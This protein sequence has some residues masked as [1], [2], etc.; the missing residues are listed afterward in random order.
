MVEES[1]KTPW[2]CSVLYTPHHVPYGMGGFHGF[3]IGSIHDAFLILSLDI[4]FLFFFYSIWWSNCVS[5]V[6]WAWLVELIMCMLGTNHTDAMFQE[7]T[8]DLWFIFFYLSFYPIWIPWLKVESMQDSALGVLHT[9]AIISR[10][11]VAVFQLVT[12]CK[13]KKFMTSYI[14]TSPKPSGFEGKQLRD[15]I[16]ACT[17]LLLLLSFIFILFLL[18]TESSPDQSFS[19]WLDGRVECRHMG[20]LHW[21]RQWHTSI[22]LSLC[23]K[24]PESF[25]VWRICWEKVE[26]KLN[27]S[28]F[29]FISIFSILLLFWLGSMWVHAFVP[30]LFVK[31]IR[32]SFTSHIY[33]FP[34]LIFPK[35]SKNF[36]F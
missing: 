2:Y 18:T 30:W 14:A 23:H 4:I 8:F 10:M 15:F 35:S 19:W 11:L 36:K 26:V 28:I 32:C 29:S 16:L 21:R 34:S 17:L 13:W 33:I 27:S 5:H 31:Y 12:C 3:H 22:D 9:E 7:R 24:F 20:C 6:W 1:N 25:L